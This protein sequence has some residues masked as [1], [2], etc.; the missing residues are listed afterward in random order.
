MNIQDHLR[1]DLSTALRKRDKTETSA[2]RTLISAI[3]NAG[4]VEATLSAEPKVGTDHDV[5]R[6]ELEDADV[7][8]IIQRERD[9]ITEAIERYRELGA[10]EQ[11]ED[12][13]VR[14]Q[15]VDRYVG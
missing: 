2:I 6:R 13:E 3:E 5:P 14:L 1:A 12:L 8:A 15:I 4:A 7:T 11:V 9:E 10:A